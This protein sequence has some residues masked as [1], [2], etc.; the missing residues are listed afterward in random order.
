[1]VIG[2]GSRDGEVVPADVGGGRRRVTGRAAGD[3][4][5]GRV[6]GARG[7]EAEHGVRGQ[8]DGLEVTG[9]QARSVGLTPA[10]LTLIL[11]CPSPG[12][13]S[14]TWTHFSTSGGPY[15]V[16]TTALGMAFLPVV[17]P[18]NT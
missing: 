14:G 16:I 3:A 18:Q 13:G 9:P 10:A 5:P 6:D 17:P 12:S 1:M 4:G 11:I 2:G 8:R 15:P 7:P